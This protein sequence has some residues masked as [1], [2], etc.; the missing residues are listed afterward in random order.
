LNFRRAEDLLRHLFE[1]TQAMVNDF[2]RFQAA[3]ED[4]A[5]DDELAP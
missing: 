1:L 4:S 5:T 2:G 3:V